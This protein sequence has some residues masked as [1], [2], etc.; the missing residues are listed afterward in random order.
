[1]NGTNTEPV[2][3]TIFEPNESYNY[4][5]IDLYTTNDPTNTTCQPDGTWSLET[6]PTC[7][8]MY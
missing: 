1:M 4:L 2:L 3:K 5:C 7:T 8:G 6:P